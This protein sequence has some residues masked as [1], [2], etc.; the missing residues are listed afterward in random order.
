MSAYLRN[1]E[2]EGY[3]KCFPE[4]PSTTED[5]SEPGLPSCDE[6]SDKDVYLESRLEIGSH[7]EWV[8]G[9]GLRHAQFTL[10]ELDSDTATLKDSNGKLFH[11]KLARVRPEPPVKPVTLSEVKDNKLFE[12]ARPTQTGTLVWEPIVVV[13]TLNRTYDREPA[14]TSSTDG[15]P[16]M[17]R[18]IEKCKST[19]KHSSSIKV[20][21]INVIRTG[22]VE[23]LNKSDFAP[24]K[25]RHVFEWTP[26]SGRWW[27]RVYAE[28]E[29]AFSR[30]AAILS[31][32]EKID[33]NISDLLEKE[34]RNQRSY[35]TGCRTATDLFVRL[36]SPYPE[37]MRGEF[38]NS[39]SLLRKGK[40]TGSGRTGKSRKR[41]KDECGCFRQA[42]RVARPSSKALARQQRQATERCVGASPAVASHCLETSADASAAQ[43]ACVQ[44]SKQQ[45]PRA[46]RAETIDVLDLCDSD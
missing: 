16:F 23:V 24:N 32:A 45:T 22:S 12:L 27:K 19:I 7:V 36:V 1:E 17:R 14:T 30:D 40:T 29:A 13:M 2:S 4:V 8:S 43:T 35:A 6:E 21:L 15:S 18:L 5:S 20:A 44:Q 33:A 25:L 10:L 9:E 38:Q 26:R 46:S 41:R 39:L 28:K 31:C 42:G 37:V 3:D 34:L 11:E